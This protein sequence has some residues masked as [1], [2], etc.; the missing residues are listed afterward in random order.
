[1]T[2]LTVQHK[3]QSGSIRIRA[4]IS[5]ASLDGSRGCGGSPAGSLFALAF[6]ERHP[7][8]HRV[9]CMGTSAWPASL[10]G[11][12]GSAQSTRRARGF[13]GSFA[14]GWTTRPGPQCI[15][16]PRIAPLP[17]RAGPT[18]STGCP[19]TSQL[20][21]GVVGSAKPISAMIS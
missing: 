11:I 6:L 17:A 9:F 3:N 12:W 14:H 13:S 8:A 15:T 1:M 5:P 10:S 18:G 19:G 20:K 21:W 2:F 7:A 4:P 16:C